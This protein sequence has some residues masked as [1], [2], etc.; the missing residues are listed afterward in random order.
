MK[1]PPL[2][3][4]PPPL[5]I[6]D[7]QISGWG[8]PEHF[9]RESNIGVKTPPLKSANFAKIEGGAFLTATIVHS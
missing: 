9:Y 3:K 6:A 4:D 5:K 1:T 8:Y 7:F 2:G